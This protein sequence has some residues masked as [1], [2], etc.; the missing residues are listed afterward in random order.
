MV[1]QIVLRQGDS[2]QLDPG[3]CVKQ[4]ILL[5]NADFYF[6][7]ET[8]AL[9]KKF[10]QNRLPQAGCRNPSMTAGHG[11]QFRFALRLCQFGGIGLM[12]GISGNKPGKEMTRSQIA[13][14]AY[15]KRDEG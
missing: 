12:Q 5:S 10:Q 11:Q 9:K 1:F 7:R 15:C 13:E 4:G 3:M 14:I 2:V 8:L 6:C